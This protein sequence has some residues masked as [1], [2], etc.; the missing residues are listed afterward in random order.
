MDTKKL[1]EIQKVVKDN[2]DSIIRRASANS[3]LVSP[4]AGFN[5]KMPSF[6]EIPAN[7]VVPRRSEPDYLKPNWSEGRLNRPSP[8]NTPSEFNIVERT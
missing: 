1:V 7:D 6:Q 2:Q 8:R 4:I 3:K 5:S